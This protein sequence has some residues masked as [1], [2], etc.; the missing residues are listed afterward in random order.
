MRPSA[1]ISAFGLC[2]ALAGA[3]AAPMLA[4]PADEPQA[5]GPELEG[6][7]YPWPVSTYAFTSQGEKLRMAYMDVKPAG[8]PNGRT[9]V[10]FHGKNFFAPPGRAPSQ[11]SP[12]PAT[13]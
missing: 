5:Y 4:Q 11:R 6:F 13:G 8:T 1:L 7:A 9:A 10:L 2:V 3:S 12:R